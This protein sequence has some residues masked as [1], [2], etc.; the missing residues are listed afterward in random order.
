MV[1][2]NE[3]SS[4]NLKSLVYKDYQVPTTKEIENK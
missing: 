3:F 1:E 4:Y 2:H